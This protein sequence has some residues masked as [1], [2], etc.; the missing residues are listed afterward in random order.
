MSERKRHYGKYRGTVTN[1]VDPLLKGRVQVLVTLGGTPLPMWAEACTPYAGPGCGL[2]AIPPAGAGVW[3]EFEEG[4]PDKP[5]WTG[6]WWADGEVMAMLNPD[7]PPPDPATAP[8]T[9]VLRTPLARLKLA[10]MTGVA[11]L[12][13]LAPPA[14]PGTP[15]VVKVGPDGVEVSY[16]VHKVRITPAGVVVNDGALMVV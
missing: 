4:D 13:S 15:T 11:T 5:I 2:Y 8:G 9:V 14:T 12:E 16:S 1:P 10:G 7:V 3:V 6:C